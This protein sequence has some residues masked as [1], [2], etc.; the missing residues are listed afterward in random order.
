MPRNLEEIAPWFIAAN[1]VLVERNTTYF[2]N[3][4]E[5]QKKLEASERANEAFLQ[6]IHEVNAALDD[7]G[8]LQYGVPDSDGFAELYP[9]KKRIQMLAERARKCLEAEEG[10]K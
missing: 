4:L 10:K 8:V 9:A 2:D 6:E 1:K 7:A 5:A 3:A